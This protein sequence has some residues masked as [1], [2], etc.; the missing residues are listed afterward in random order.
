MSLF[1]I[2]F[3]NNCT[4]FTTPIKSVFILKNFEPQMIIIFGLELDGIKTQHNQSLLEY[5]YLF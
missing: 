4:Q 5:Q 3:E 2:G 1:S